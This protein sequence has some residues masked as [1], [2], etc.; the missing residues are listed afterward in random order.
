MSFVSGNNNTSNEAIQKFL[1][2]LQNDFRTLANETRKKYPQIK[3]VKTFLL[4]KCQTQS[5]CQFA[6]VHFNYVQL[7]FFFSVWR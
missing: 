1:E 6:K 5:N 2:I 7:I 4:S 3:E